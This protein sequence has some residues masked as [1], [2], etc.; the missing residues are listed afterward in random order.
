MGKTKR[1]YFVL[2]VEV[3]PVNLLRTDKR[4]GRME[5]LI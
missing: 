4:K 2:G 1:G 3:A 5:G